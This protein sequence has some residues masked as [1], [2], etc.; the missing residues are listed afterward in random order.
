MPGRRQFRSAANLSPLTRQWVA[1][2]KKPTVAQALDK[3]RLA[4]FERPPAR[5][6]RRSPVGRAALQG[7]LQGLP[8]P[9]PGA[10]GERAA[11]PLPCGVGGRGARRHSFAKRSRSAY[12]PPCRMP[13]PVCR[14]APRSPCRS[15]TSDEHAG[16]DW[17]VI[18]APGAQAAPGLNGSRTPGHEGTGRRMS[19]PPAPAHREPARPNRS[20]PHRHPAIPR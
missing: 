8:P 6:L 2:A 7:E 10:G 19:W 16:A 14:P 11:A 12:R 17:D 13:R 1:D 18:G 3:A 20:V 15:R 9:T 5:R 4:D